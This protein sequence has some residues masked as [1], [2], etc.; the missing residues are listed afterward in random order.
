MKN[1][2]KNIWDAP[3]STIA[4][5]VVAG[6]GIVTVSDIELNPYFILCLS[7][8]AAFLAV[9]DGPNKTE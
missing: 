2:F 5:G 3:A 6:I 1:L 9:F 7:A 8:V 4:G